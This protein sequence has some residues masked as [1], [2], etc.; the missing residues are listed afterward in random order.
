MSVQGRL[1][2]NGSPLTTRRVPL[3]PAVT[4]S[5]IKNVERI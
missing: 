1:F 3:R 4:L 5:P 2:K